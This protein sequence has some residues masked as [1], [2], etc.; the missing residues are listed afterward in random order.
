MDGH[1]RWRCADANLPSL[2]LLKGVVGGT[3]RTAFVV[4]TPALAL[5]PLV[6]LRPVPVPPF[7]LG[8]KEG[9]DVGGGR[10]SIGGRRSL[11]ISDLRL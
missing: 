9:D 3:P 8:E 7:V 11:S 5:I 6:A 1:H 10:S 2:V 4:P